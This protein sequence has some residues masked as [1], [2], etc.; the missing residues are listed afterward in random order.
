MW[1]GLVLEL[2]SMRGGLLLTVEVFVQVAAAHTAPFDGDEGFVIRRLWDG[3]IDDADVLLTE[4]L[5]C[6]HSG[7]D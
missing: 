1:N 5:C 4:V 6:F 7:H 3:N 2:V